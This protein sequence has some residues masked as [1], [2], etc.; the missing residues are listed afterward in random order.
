MPT[1]AQ[2]E[3][4]L[5]NADA[6]GD[7]A[8]AKQ[9]A[10][11][12]KAGQYDQQQT[13]SPA[14]LPLE[15]GNIDLKARPV[16]KNADGTISTVRSLSFQPDRGGP[17][18]LI[19]TVSDD[20]RILSDDDAINLY[21]QTGKHLGKFRTPQEA[22]SYAEQLHRDQERQYAPLAQQDSPSM[23]D[24]AETALRVPA[25]MLREGAKGVAALPG[26][27]GDV[28]VSLPF[29]AIAGMLGYGRSPSISETINR[30]YDEISSA[31]G[32]DPA[33]Q[34]DTE[35]YLGA[36]SRGAGGAVGGV[37]I[38][39]Q[40][41]TAAGPVTS[42][43]GR[44]L[45]SQPVAQAVA[46]ASS[47]VGSQLAADAGA[48]PGGQ[49]AAGLAAGIGGG[50]A[51]SRAPTPQASLPARAA[52]TAEGAAAIRRQA[53][54][55]ES[56]AQE[57]A[58]QIG[59]N[60]GA[61]EAGLKD[62]IMKTIDDAQAVDSTLPPEALARKAIY[63][64]LGIKPTKALITRN[65][66]DA[67]NEQN[68]LTEPEGQALRN[69][70]I[71]NNQTIRQNIRGLAGG[72]AVDAPT[73]GQQFRS[74]LEKGAEQSRRTTGKFYEAA[75]K[76]EGANEADVSDLFGYLQSNRS[77]LASSGAGKPVISF[78]KDAG[79]WGKK[80]ST[81][82][83]KGEPIELDRPMTLAELTDLRA[84][85]NRESSAFSTTPNAQRLYGNMRSI[86]DDAEAAAGGQAF[87]KAR[88]VFGQQKSVWEGNPLLVNL[89]KDKQGFR[90]VEQ[91]PDEQVF[92]KAIIS[93]TD[94]DFSTVWNRSDAKAKDLTRTQLASY[95]EEKV[96]SNQGTNEAGDVVASAAKLNAA[97]REINPRKLRMIYGP[98]KAATLARLNTAVR[99]ISNPPRGTVATGSAPA[100]KALY[101]QTLSLLGFAG[102]IPGINVVV[103]V[104]EKRA[105]SN[106]RAA[107]AAA[108][109]TPVPAYQ[110]Q[111]NLLLQSGQRLSPL[112]LPAATTQNQ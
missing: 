92:N 3:S 42:A 12:L 95:I 94:K 53:Q 16:V 36:A 75:R 46:G 73:Y 67:L 108:A 82:Y 63:E 96:F 62:R 32:V 33:P 6:A 102:K 70:Y 10:N 48:G 51:A 9:L 34:T 99:E 28:M 72:N 59:L 104:A 43:V 71:E 56:T 105:A 65:F 22:T 81:A 86:L 107:Q 21:M 27:A 57:A 14:V 80:A 110:P 50:L 61:L 24:Y 23:G 18:V 11:A 19:P 58:G 83:A 111:Q 17:E 4:A 78:M 74:G 100:L 91:I 79:L 1:R 29:N 30:G 31:V 98:E 5:R 85:I 90:N 112:L 39:N 49:M 44:M 55:L 41:A 106:A 68:L 25:T 40:L 76:A 60:W 26:L 13:P 54:T 101:R 84:L 35:R 88:K 45:A 2:L 109:A 15:A 20:G 89:L 7:T 37:G 69:L 97:L 93:S 47:G 52:T 8:A 66:D 103:D 87:E 77:S 64:S 38:G